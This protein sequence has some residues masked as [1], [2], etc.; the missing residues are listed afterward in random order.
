[1]NPAITFNP[2]LNDIEKSI[3]IDA[4]AAWWAKSSPAG[5]A[6]W[7]RGPDNVITHL[8]FVC[9][10]GCRRVIM[11]PVNAHGKPPSQPGWNWNRDEVKPTLSPSIL[12]MDGCRW[13]GY[14]TNGVW[15]R[16]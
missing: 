14:L 1:M 5:E 11:I 13:H 15:Q 6:C 4:G 16:C 7:M 8:L 10:C 3:D 9:P 12:R 2:A